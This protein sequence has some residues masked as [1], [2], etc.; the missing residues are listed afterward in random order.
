MS[1][2]LI[3]DDDTALC[4]MLAEYLELEEFRVSLAHDGQTALEIALKEKPDAILLD[5]MMP[6]MNGFD[7]LRELRKKSAIP[8][9]M[10]T[11][12]GDEVDSI[13][14]LEL[15]AD[16][17]LGKPGSPR[18][19]VARLRALLRRS[20]LSNEPASSND[21][22]TIS[23]LSVD[24][25]SRTATLGND[26]LNLTSSEF[27]IL[28]VLARS[29]GAVMSKNGLSEAAMGRPLELFDRSIDM[30]VSH[31]RKKLGT[32]PEGR[33][34]IKTVRGIGYQLTVQ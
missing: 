9:L 14:G 33:E 19:I 31:L 11:A 7:M 1:H 6:R 34:R 17:Y 18:L 16:D 5:V 2:I 8:V 3:A 26:A 29:A 13:V 25:A 20:K 23:D 12:R 28:L 27:N 21:P 30:H 15:G 22:I 4:A 10:L 32:T 24:A